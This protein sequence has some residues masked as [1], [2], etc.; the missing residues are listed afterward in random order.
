VQIEKEAGTE[1]R[2]TDLMVHVPEESSGCP[3]KI[4]QSLEI[5]LSLIKRNGFSEICTARN[6]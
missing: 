6:P 4:R 2:G 1:Y 3:L 5:L